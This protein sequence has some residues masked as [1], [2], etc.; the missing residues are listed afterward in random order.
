MGMEDIG[1]QE[2]F[3][4]QSGVEGSHLHAVTT[5]HIFRFSSKD[6][7]SVMFATKE[8]AESPT[9]SEVGELFTG[10]ELSAIP[11]VQRDLLA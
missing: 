4:C 8:W 10:H 7:G 6:D 1:H 2:R 9:W 3:L 5:A 11:C